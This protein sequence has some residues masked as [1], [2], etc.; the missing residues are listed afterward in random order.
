M[1]FDYTQ[2]EAANNEIAKLGISDKRKRNEAIRKSLGNYYDASDDILSN[3]GYSLTSNQNIDPTIA[4]IFSDFFEQDQQGKDYYRGADYSTAQVGTGGYDLIDSGLGTYDITKDGKK[5]GTYYDSVANAINDYRVK[6]ATKYANNLVDNS[7][8]GK[9]VGYKEGRWV[10]NQW[11]PAHWYYKQQGSGDSD[12]IT[13]L[14]GATQEEAIA[15]LVD[16]SGVANSYKSTKGPLYDWELL[17]QELSG[18]SKYG[19]LLNSNALFDTSN[20]W[21]GDNKN[22]TI[23]GLDTL[24]GSTPIM[25]NDSL[26][27]Y[28]MDLGPN[29]E[30]VRGYK[31]PLVNSDTDLKGSTRHNYTQWRDIGDMSKWAELGK[32][33]DNTGGFFAPIA[34]VEKL[35]GWTQGD[36]NK[37]SHKSNSMFSNAI[38]AI[39]TILQFTPLSGLGYL[40]TMMAN[41]YQ[42]NPVGALASFAG[43]SG[44][45]GTLA[46]KL[47][48]ATGLSEP[49]S[50]AIS[51]GAI[52]GALSKLG[53]GNFGTGA[54]TSALG[55]MTSA[56]LKD[57]FNSDAIASVGGSLTK[58]GLQQLFGK[59][60]ISNVEQFANSLP[61]YQQQQEKKKQA[62]T[63][64]S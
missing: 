44:L 61:L 41:A 59:S 12:I 60:N 38:K 23:S 15:N 14:E 34:N 28:L 5:L 32:F 36:V 27:G 8:Y 50:K 53:G 46:N 55:S 18:N 39:G 9:S 24:F 13:P 51:S 40:T 2:L 35:P 33:T 57:L 49:V 25:W 6:D 58:S 31:N 37:Y 10:D 52:G 22:T 16:I 63:E 54:L 20:A 64:E 11:E 47:G 29:T 45:T 56:Q 1:D 30:N 48:G 7:A 62:T 21:I 17:G 42:G 19:G 4:N 43:G 3:Q 26:L